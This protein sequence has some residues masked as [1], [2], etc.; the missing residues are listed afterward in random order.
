MLRHLT[1]NSFLCSVWH[2]ERAQVALPTAVLGTGDSGW[3]QSFFE[4]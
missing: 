3:L 2:F 4:C 1:Q